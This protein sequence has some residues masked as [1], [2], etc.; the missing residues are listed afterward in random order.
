MGNACCNYSNGPGGKDPHAM[1]D[2]NNGAGGKPIKMDPKVSE[3][4]LVELRKQVKKLIRIQAVMRGFLVRRHLKNEDH[5]HQRPRASGRR[6]NRPANTGGAVA[7]QLNE[8]PDYS[9]SATRAT[10]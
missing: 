7:R 1:G 6:S 3:E 9:N 10:E 8:M 4:V 2:E 5:A